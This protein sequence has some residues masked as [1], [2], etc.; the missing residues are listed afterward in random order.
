MDID[1]TRLHAFMGSLLGDMGGAVT[2]AMMCLGEELGLYEALD[3]QGPTTPD[4][5]AARAGCN[6]RLVR[7]WADQQTAA[8]YLTYEETTDAYELPVEHGLALAQRQSPAYVAGGAWLFASIFAD[9]DRLVGAFR[10][11]GGLAWGDHNPHLFRGTAEFLRPIYQH[12]LV[13][14][15]IPALDGI[16]QRLQAGV[17]VADVG[18]GHGVTSILMA[19]R[20]PASTFHGFD[21]HPPSVDS[22]REAAGIAGVADRV[23]VSVAQADTYGGTYELICFFDCLHDMGDPEGI[24]RHARQHLDEGGSVL[25]VEPFALDARSENHSVPTAKIFYGGSTAVCTPASLAQPVGKAMGAQ[26]GPAAMR[27]VFARAG[28]SVFEERARTP[29]NVVYQAQV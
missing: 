14:A 23:H 27:D 4:D 6:P 3:G 10:G 28:F 9:L 13:D 19:Q 7:E 26:A 22:A 25:L 18:C 5:L 11:D 29:F 8:G 12:N 15:W 1:E 21:V 2:V 24:A 17:S 16:E 20:F